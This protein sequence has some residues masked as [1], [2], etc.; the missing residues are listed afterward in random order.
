MGGMAAFIPIKGDEEANA[1]AIAKVKADKLRE[2]KTAT[3]EHGCASAL[4]K[5]AMDVSG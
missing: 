4:V 2:V 3:M 5:V 1:A